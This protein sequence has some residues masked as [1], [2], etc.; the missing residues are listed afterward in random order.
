MSAEKAAATESTDGD[1]AERS[2]PRRR[3]CLLFLDGV[4]DPDAAP[5]PKRATQLAVNAA[6]AADVPESAAGVSP[7][8]AP[9]ISA[10]RRK[11]VDR[12]MSGFIIGNTHAR[13]LLTRQEAAELAKAPPVGPGA[14]PQPTKLLWIGVGDVRNALTTLSAFPP[15]AYVELHMNDMS[16]AVLARNV[17]LLTMATRE[18][19]PSTEPLTAKVEDETCAFLQLLFVLFCALCV[20]CSTRIVLFNEIESNKHVAP[21]RFPCLCG[22]VERL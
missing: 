12:A 8:A 21:A 15:R 13:S 19:C 14:T 9:R 16:S 7:V 1:T 4:V 2:S 18:V 10:A 5:K 20:Q 3:R 17:V 6:A 22:C 11:L